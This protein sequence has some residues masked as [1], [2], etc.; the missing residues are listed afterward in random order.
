MY[1]FS[2]VVIGTLIVGLVGVVIINGQRRKG[3]RNT[4][5]NPWTRSKKKGQLGYYYGHQQQISGEKLDAS[6]YAMNKPIRLDPISKKPLDEKGTRMSTPE[7]KKKSTSP[8][9]TS[10]QFRQIT[11]YAWTDTETAVTIYI[12]HKQWSEDSIVKFDLTTPTSLRL[13]LTLNDGFS[14][15][16]VLSPLYAAISKMTSKKTAKRLTLK[17][18]KKKEKVKWP[19]LL[20]PVN[21][22]V[23]DNIDTHDELLADE[24]D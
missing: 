14:Y 16:L 3:S 11:Q 12:E 22:A 19:S 9:S 23:L 17:L 20:G 21:S 2:S 6:V 15:L 10:T 1:Y 5:L 8:N 24:V 4:V 18:M 13:E 7:A